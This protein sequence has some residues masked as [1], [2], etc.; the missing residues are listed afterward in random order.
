MKAR[1]LGLLAGLASLGLGASGCHTYK[2]VDMTVTFDQSIDDGDILAIHDCRMLVSGAD[3]DSF[4][5]ANCPPAPTVPDPHVGVVFEFSTFADSGT[6]HFEF[7]GYQGLN[8]TPACLVLD[9]KQDVPVTSLTTIPATMNVLKTGSGCQN[10]VTDG[11][12]GGGGG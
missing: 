12:T 1:S 3:S 9:G 5:L 7:Q 10:N 11:G 8:E 4:L 2:Y 6:L